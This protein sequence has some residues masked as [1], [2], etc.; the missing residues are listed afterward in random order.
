[1]KA[2]VVESKQLSASKQ[3]IVTNK[4]IISLASLAT[5]EYES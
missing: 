4:F 2:I 3:L 1:M 5:M